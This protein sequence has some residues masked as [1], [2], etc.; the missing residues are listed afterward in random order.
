[1]ARRGAAGHNRKRLSI[2]ECVPPVRDLII[3]LAA[4][5]KLPAVYAYRSNTNDSGETAAKIQAHVIVP[6]V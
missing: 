1:V 4:Q 5:Y 2:W 6:V 3:K